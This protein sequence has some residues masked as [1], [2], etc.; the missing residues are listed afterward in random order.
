MTKPTPCSLCG[1]VS[2]YL[3]GTRGFCGAHRVEAVEASKRQ[4]SKKLGEGSKFVPTAAE[5]AEYTRA[6][7]QAKA[8]AMR[9]IS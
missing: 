3:V 7:G 1:A 9:E 6:G 2:W 5:Y 4:G 8:K